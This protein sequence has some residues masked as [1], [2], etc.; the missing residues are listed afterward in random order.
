LSIELRRKKVV[1]SVIEK[2]LADGRAEFRPGDIAAYL[3]ERN[4]PMGVWE[5]RRELS[6]LEADGVIENDADS[7]AWRAAAERSRKAG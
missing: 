6:A 5:I 3:R 2:L 4:Q 1:L 7:G